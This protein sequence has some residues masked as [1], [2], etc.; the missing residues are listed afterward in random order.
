MGKYNLTYLDHDSER[1]NMG[2]GIVDLDVNNITAQLA[3]LATLKAAVEAI[4]IGSLDK[5]QVIAVTT[6]LAATPPA[7]GLAQREAKWLVTGVDTQGLNC[8]IEIP[9]ADLTL[10]AAG[11]KNLDLSAGTGLALKDALDACWVSKIGNAVTV[12]RVIHVGRNI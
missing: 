2:I 10:L 7:S 11:T 8:S 6:E 9:T 5:E 12:G 3:L 4:V 1:S